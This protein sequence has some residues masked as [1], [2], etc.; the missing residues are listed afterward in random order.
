MRTSAFFCF[1]LLQLAIVGCQKSLPST[2]SGTITIDGNPL[3]E[4]ANTTGEVMYYPVAGGAAAYGTISTGG[5][6]K[7]QTGGTKGLQPGEY[8]VTVRLV[9]IPPPP[10]GGYQNAPPNKL[11]SPPKY[12]DRDQTDLKVEVTEGGNTFDLELTTS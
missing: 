9:E 4:D 2:V 3:P 7:M 5:Q 8:V 11:I 1:C 10:P 6:Y 12:N